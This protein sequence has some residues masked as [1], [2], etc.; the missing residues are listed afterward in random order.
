MWVPRCDSNTAFASGARGFVATRVFQDQGNANTD[1]PAVSAMF[2]PGPPVQQHAKHGC[3]WCVHVGKA[4]VRKLRPVAAHSD[5]D[6]FE[7]ELLACEVFVVVRAPRRATVVA[8]TWVAPLSQVREL[9]LQTLEDGPERAPAATP[10]ATHCAPPGCRS[11]TA[12]QMPRHESV[13]KKATP[14]KYT[15]RGSSVSRRLSR[16]NFVRLVVLGPLFAV[17]RSSH[18]FVEIRS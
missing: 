5:H 14:S 10:A 16:C 8:C 15:A 7:A 1:K 3:S 12:S 18:H 2:P 11:A 4:S 6:S 13:R 17:D 9:P